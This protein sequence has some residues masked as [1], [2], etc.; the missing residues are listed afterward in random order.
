VRNK[1]L[2]D[3]NFF[4]QEFGKRHPDVKIT[5]ML[6]MNSDKEM[7]IY[8]VDQLE[9]ARDIHVAAEKKSGNVSSLEKYEFL[10]GLLKSCVLKGGFPPEITEFRRRVAKLPSE[11]REREFNRTLALVSKW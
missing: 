2:K 11:Q 1:E 6:H 4:L 10:A 5:P 9:K 3:I 7:Y 8:L